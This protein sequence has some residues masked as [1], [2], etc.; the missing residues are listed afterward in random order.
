MGQVEIAVSEM[1]DILV[2]LLL[3][4][5]GDE[6]QGMKRGTIDLADLVLI[7]KADGSLRDL[8]HV[9][10]G[11]YRQALRLVRRPEQDK[12]VEVLGV[13][14][15]KDEGISDVLMKLIRMHEDM[16][17]SGALDKRRGVQLKT[18]FWNEIRQTLIESVGGLE[19]DED[20]IIELEGKVI[21]GQMTGSLAAR[22]FINERVGTHL[23]D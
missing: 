6:L 21:L 19:R 13:S 18:W 23:G 9:T 15:A 3:P 16:R 12:K 5:A 17:E 11:D 2:L 10:V 8:A 4:G 14:A 20:Q 7:N 1:I 22:K